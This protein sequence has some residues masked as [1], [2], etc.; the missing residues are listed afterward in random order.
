MLS[1]LSKENSFLDRSFHA[2][3]EN[4][5]QYDPTAALSLCEVYK[6]GSQDIWNE[7]FL[8]ESK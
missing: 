2:A 5:E 7:T 6:K 4:L 3:I 1:L 8:G